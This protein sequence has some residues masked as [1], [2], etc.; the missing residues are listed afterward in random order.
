MA[1]TSI[2]AKP[3]RTRAILKGRYIHSTYKETDHGPVL[4]TFRLLTKHLA[5]YSL[6]ARSYRNRRRTPHAFIH[7]LLMRFKNSSRVLGSSLN[8]KG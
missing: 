1:I 8:E 5:M 2:K 6:I 7:F 4:S 3:I